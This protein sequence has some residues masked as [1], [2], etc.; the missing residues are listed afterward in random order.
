MTGTLRFC[1]GK[2]GIVVGLFV[3]SLLISG[4]ASVLPQSYALIERPPTNLPTRIELVEV[5]FFPQ[6]EYQCGPAAL[7]MIL[8]HSGVKI[9]PETLVDQVYLPAR[10]GSL[11]VEL[12]A[13]ARRYGLVPYEVSGS[14]TNILLEIAAGNPVIVLENYRYGLGPVWHYAVAIGYDSDTGR[15]IRRS[16][17]KSYESLP[18]AAFEYL[19]KADKYWAMIALPPNRLPATAD[20]DRFID[21][22]VALEKTGRHDSAREAYGTA[23]KRW[24]DSPV[25]AVGLANAAY[26]MK[27]LV[28]AEQSLREAVRR[29]PDSRIITNNLANVLSEQGKAVE[30]KLFAQRALN[31]G[32][33][34]D[35]ESRITLEKIISN[36]PKTED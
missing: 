20:H 30:A 2:A 19:W 5:P 6:D 21:A 9:T 24:E 25:A 29:H 23:L 22:V 34:E 11:Q 36:A 3:S 28:G 14:L 33:V 17:T 32:L 35:E 13:T 18:F 1:M 31:L 15:I 8:N 10:K 4:C 16:G 27:D 7:A 26:A 12:L